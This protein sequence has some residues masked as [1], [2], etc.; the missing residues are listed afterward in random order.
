MGKDEEMMQ[1]LRRRRGPSRALVFGGVGG[2]VVL[3]VVLALV[4]GRGEDRAS[5]AFSALSRCMI[6]EP[7]RDG[8][9]VFFRIREVELGERLRP[10]GSGDDAW[11]ARCAPH[12]TELYGA[13]DGSGRTALLQRLL[14]EQLGCG[15][16][17]TQPCKFEGSGQPLPKADETWNAAKL[18][19]LE[20][21]EAP[22]AQP[23]KT[24]LAPALGRELPSLGSAEL[25]LADHRFTESGE[26]WLLLRPGRKSKLATR[27]CR[28]TPNGD[29]A[30]CADAP[31]LPRTLRDVRLL[32]DERSPIVSGYYEAEGG[33]ERGA[34]ALPGGAPQ[35]TRLEVRNGAAIEQRSD[36]LF[37]LDVVDG[38]VRS[39]SKLD[40]PR[41]AE[42]AVFSG[43][44]GWLELDEKAQ[45]RRLKFRKL[46]GGAALDK[47][48]IELEGDVPARVEPCTTRGGGVFYGRSGEPPKQIAWFL[49]KNGWS[50]PVIGELP[51]AQ[52]RE[53]TA[54]CSPE[55]LTRNWVV[56]EGEQPQLGLLDCSPSGC[57]AARVAW[58]G[59]PVKQWLAIAQLGGTALALYES[60]Q[61]DKRLRLAPIERLAETDPIVLIDG[62]E[63]SGPKFQGARV[64]I[65][66]RLVLVL[67]DDE[68]ELH[69]LYVNADGKYGAVAL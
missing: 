45:R 1:A 52:R 12:A 29:K 33:E 21:V 31:A 68:Q 35:K 20:L 6:G 65:G 24:R 58:K 64:L 34:F 44:V 51:E 4:L 60:F 62:S 26:L 66:P 17:E 22:Q 14:R 56:T 53:W 18:A 3:G 49:G 69:A 61:D 38:L 37:L 23:P 16:A 59:E 19:G 32:A 28:V 57:K 50:R 25:E 55:R 27:L 15:D 41:G 46:A 47:S 40:L 13:I 8:E 36:G 63:Y 67:F 30:S 5:L 7:L 39:Q 42:A 54:V 2:V 10:S 43:F 48:V 11:P 9:N